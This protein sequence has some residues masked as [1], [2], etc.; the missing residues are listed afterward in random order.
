MSSIFINGTQYFVSKAL[1]AAIPVTAI[2]N[3]NPAVAT[4][5]SPPA[6]GAIVVVASGWSG[7]NETVARTANAAAD[8]FELAGVNTTNESRFPPGLGAGSVREVTDWTPLI[9]VRSADLSGGEQQFYQYQ[10]VEDP[11]SRQRQKP[12]FKNPMV[13]TIGLDYDP[14]LQWYEDLIAADEAGVPVVLRTVLPNGSEILYYAYPSFNKVPT[15]TLN[16]NMQNTATFSLISDPVRYDG[17][18]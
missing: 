10:Y 6:D 2:S 12:T 15:Q 16:E 8:S 4:S 1:A 11:S 3:A 18:A 14:S 13:L 5:A 17:V 9:Q 7:L